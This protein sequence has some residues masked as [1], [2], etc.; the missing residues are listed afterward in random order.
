MSKDEKTMF[1]VPMRKRWTCYNWNGRCKDEDAQDLEIFGDEC[2]GDL[3]NRPTWCPMIEIASFIPIERRKLKIK[4][5]PRE[6]ILKEMCIKQG[7]VPS[8]C[9][10]SGELIFKIV[11]FQ[12]DPCMGCNGNRI[13]CGGRVYNRKTK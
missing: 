1:M 9:T 13:V 5:D 11:S 6:D 4:N 10:L 12:K 3:N 7:Y 2:T 8:K